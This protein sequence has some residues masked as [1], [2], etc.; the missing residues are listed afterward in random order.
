MRSGRRGSCRNFPMR[1]SGESS[2]KPRFTDPAATD[3]L[4][5][6][7][8]ARRDKVVA[9]WINAVCPVVDP[10]LSPDGALTFANAA[11]DARAATPA[12]RYDLQWFRF[13]NAG[14]QPHAGR[15][16]DR[17]DQRLGARAGRAPGDWRIRGR[18]DHWQASAA[19]RLGTYRRPS[20]SVAQ[21]NRHPPSRGSS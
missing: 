15:R 17:R 9:A 8:I 11:L 14:R 10:V 2:R 6:T 12:E 4:T 19:S 18:D 13:D 1:R 3:Y 21:R 20:S 5:R 7:L 16:R